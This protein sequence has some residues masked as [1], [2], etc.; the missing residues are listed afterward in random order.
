MAGLMGTGKSVLAHNLAPR[1]GAEVIR[2]DV[3]RKELFAHNSTKQHPDSF[4]HG[5][6]SGELSLRTYAKALELATDELHRGRSV[7]IDASYK[8]REE[9][10]RAADAAKTGNA[11]FF[12]IE[13][14]APEGIVKERL[15][16]RWMAGTDPSDGRW[17]LYIAQKADFE[18]VTELPSEMYL[19]LDTARA[20]EASMED[21]LWKISG[22][23]LPEA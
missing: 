19:A 21:A 1:L 17:E 5:I 13:C 15:D 6:Y 12:V 3:L 14:V 4:G 23:V 22:F 11:G 9:R 18:P 8:R 7:I 2:T 20:P 16:A 10:L